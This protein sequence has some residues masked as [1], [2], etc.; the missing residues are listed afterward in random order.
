MFGFSVFMNEELTQEMFDYIEEMAQAGFKGIFTSM[1]IPEDDAAH[2][3]QRLSVL[4]RQAKKRQLDL[5]VDISGEALQRAGFSFEG[6]EELL[7]LGVTGLRMD[8]AISNH[9]IA[10]L[11]H[12]LK[13][14]LNAS[15][16]S[17]QDIEELQAEQAD[18][19]NLEAWHNYY[20]RPETGLERH[21]FEKK[22]Q[23]LKQAGFTVQAFVPGDAHLRGPLFAGLPT[24]EEH[25]YQHPLASALAMKSVGS[26]DLIYIGD[27]GLTQKTKEQFKRFQE[28]ETILLHVEDTG[29]NYFN[30]ILGAHENRRDEAR[31]VIRSADARFREVPLITQQNTVTRTCGSVTIDNDKYLRYMGEI[32]ICKNELPQDEKVNVVGRIIHEDLPLIQQIKAGTNFYLERVD[33]DGKN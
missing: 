4:G 1:H 7:A 14:S 17:Q 10:K 31:D 9:Q 21:W 19:T 15:T 6:I 24:L 2:Y 26:V 32:Q 18:F 12:Q 11:S 20:P 23:W 28:E 30:Y 8:Y 13:I 5:M 33:D 22:N 3:R 29:T 25:R 27:G 16:V